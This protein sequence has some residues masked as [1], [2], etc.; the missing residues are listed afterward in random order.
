MRL[1]HIILA[2]LLTLVI[3]A[4]VG[5]AA[6][7]EKEKLVHLH[8][9]GMLTEKP[10]EDPFGLSGARWISMKELL[11]KLEKIRKDDSVVGLALTFGQL[12]Y[13][14]GQMEE[15]HNALQEIQESGKKT[16]VHVEDLNTGAYALFSPVSEISVVPTSTIWLTGLYGQGLYLK[17]TLDK[18]GIDADFLHM[19]DYK[20]AGEIFTRTEPS[21]EAEENMNWLMDS[22]FGSLVKMIANSRGLEEDKVRDLV[23]QGLLSPESAKEAGLVAHVEYRDEF[24]DRIKKELGEDIEIDNRYEKEEETEIDLSNPFAFFTFLAK[25][26][27]KAG[28]G[29]GD[30]IGLVY[31]EGPIVPG[32]EEPNPFGPVGAAHSGNI[33]KAL[34]EAAEDD[35]V[36]AVVLRV[37]SP[38]GSALASEIIWRAVTQLKEKKP[39]VVSM[40]NMAASGGYYVS[41]GADKILADNTTLTASIGVVGGKLVTTGMWDK[42]G[43]NWHEYKRGS[44]SDLMSTLTDWSADQRE[45]MHSWMATVY[46]DFKGHVIDGRGAK[47]AKPIDEI[48]GGRV[49]TGQ[50]ALNLGLVDE[51]GGLSEA[52]IAAATLASATDYKVRVIPEPVSPLVALMEEMSGGGDRPSDLKMSVSSDFLP[53]LD[54]LERVDP[55]RLTAVKTALKRLEL[56]SREG[57]VLMPPI[58]FV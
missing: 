1:Q 25:Q 46:E 18:L 17:G 43:F 51:I 11:E 20:A 33:S 34:E 52:I 44:N 38:G 26:M 3:H 35:S 14:F 21:K 19:G 32:Y 58:D 7:K 6:D 57:V 54:I 8:L 5:H 24:L 42:V 56:I 10:M 36:K 22:L 40:G 49:Y 55:K 53:W 4:P 29:K 41:C 12:P 39:V 50:Q 45:L 28:N 13:G 31:V 27:E 9:N 2:I 30:A 47:L 23:D 15:I 16:Y 37:D 48:A